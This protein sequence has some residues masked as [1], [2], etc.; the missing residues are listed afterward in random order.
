[1]FPVPHPRARVVWTRIAG[2]TEGIFQ[3]GHIQES[4][5]RPNPCHVLLPGLAPLI[6]PLPLL[7]P[8]LSLEAQEWGCL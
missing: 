5:L 4:T 8:E 6:C 2:E 3:K 7:G 1:M